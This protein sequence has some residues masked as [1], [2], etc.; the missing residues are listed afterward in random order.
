MIDPKTK[1]PYGTYNIRIS[2]A[3]SL[4]VLK[5]ALGRIKE[6]IESD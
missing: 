1:K 6:M 3:S 5:E 4:T 2:I